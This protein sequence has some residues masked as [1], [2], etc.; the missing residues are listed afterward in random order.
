MKP[1][2]VL[3]ASEHTELGFRTWNHTAEAIWSH[4]LSLFFVLSGEVTFR[5]SEQFHTLTTGSMIVCNPG[6]LFT[7]ETL[8]SSVALEICIP[9]AQLKTAGW[10][11]VALTTHGND[12]SAEP[13][14]ALFSQLFFNYIQDQPVH[15]EQVNATLQWLSDNCPAAPQAPA[16]SDRSRN[17]IQTVLRYLLHN[18]AQPLSLEDAAAFAELSASHLSHL[19]RTVL[20]TSFSEYLISLRLHKAACL[21]LQ[22]ESSITDIGLDVGFSSTNMFIEH[23]RRHFGVTPGRYRRLHAD[24]AVPLST[25]TSAPDFSRLM[26]YISPSFL[27]KQEECEKQQITLDLSACHTEPIRPTWRNLLN[28]GYARC[29][30]LAPIQEQIR[31]A[32]REI[33]FRYVRFHGIFDSDMHIYE[34]NA[35]EQPVYNFLYADMLFDFLLSVGLH[36]FLELSFM[37]PALAR[38]KEYMWKNDSFSSIYN[39]R[40][41]W[42]AL[43]QTTLRHLVERYGMEEVRQWKFTS[44]QL[45][46]EKPLRFSILSESNYYDFY[47][48]TRSTVKSV[49]P[50][51][52]FGG[53]GC[54]ASSLWDGDLI[55]NF[56]EFCKE[57]DCLPDFFTFQCYPDQTMEYSDAFI[58][59]TR[60]QRAEPLIISNDSNY[61][62]HFLQGIRELLSQYHVDEPQIWLEEWNSTVWQRDISSDTVY[63][64]A[65]LVKNICETMPLAEGF[66]YWTLSD[67]IEERPLLQPA[68]FHGGFGLMTMNGLPKTGWTA[69][70]LLQHL[71]EQKIGSGDGWFAAHSG[72]SIQL[73][74]YHYCHYDNLHRHRNLTQNSP[75]SAYQVFLRRPPKEII[76][77]IEGLGDRPC[78]VKRYT[79]SRTQGSIFD[80]WVA[81]GCPAYPSQTD[82]EYLYHAGQPALR[83]SLE[84][85]ENGTLTLH[86]LLQ[87]HEIQLWCIDPI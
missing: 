15:E 63:K 8:R 60:H 7:L 20:G 57:H 41:K 86:A 21:L 32:Q 75:Q 10:Q 16:V 2:I 85:P 80:C 9:A 29:G 45:N 65:W 70:T 12:S 26:Q 87:P 52:T 71:G 17:H 6:I 72:S 51:L 48:T 4:D 56:V 14:R 68:L 36:P 44:I 73:L 47:T 5:L 43:V 22:S 38:N 18:F 42:I 59:A 39:N 55:R 62:Q 49:D 69:L 82:M 76:A 11:P 35:N 25:E 23:F 84:M 50:Q 81:L 37:P 83:T 30:L 77:V 28:I 53:P 1:I 78:R 67:L 34:E 3:T 66:G 61:V 31:T 40:E 64:S 19:F 13:L 74:F 54:F 58:A 79:L 27:K 33:G 46:P 24:E